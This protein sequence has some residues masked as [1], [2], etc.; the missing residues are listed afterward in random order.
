VSSSYVV[1][2]LGGKERSHALSLSLSEKGN[3]R[4]RMTSLET[5]LHFNAS[6]TS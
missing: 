1:M 6:H 4:N 2:H 5:P 3:S